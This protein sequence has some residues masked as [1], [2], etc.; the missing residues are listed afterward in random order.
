MLVFVDE[1]GDPGMQ[2]KRGSSSLFIITAVI[3]LDLEDASACD[4]R[5]DELRE[6]CFHNHRQEFK[7]NKCCHDHRMAF[8]RAM[9]DYEFLYLT[10][11]L[12]KAKLLGPGFQ[13]K[14]SFYKYTSRLLFENAKSYL[15]RATVVIDGSGN[16]EFRRELQ[17]Y[18][19]RKINTETLAISKVKTEA[20]HTNNLLQLAD[21]ICGA[22]ARSYREEKGERFVYRR[23][24]GRKELKIV[25]WPKN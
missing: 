20:S 12:N 5:I 8:L 10:F 19:K 4:H 22:V 2:Q 25:F 7:F 11:V 14:S 15:S 13:N 23:I 16:R 24:I 18:L 9:G 6:Q 21:M 17:S 3:F 1:S